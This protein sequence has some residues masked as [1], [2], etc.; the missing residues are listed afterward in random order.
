MG[1]YF[2]PSNLDQAVY[3]KRFTMFRSSEELYIYIY[4]YKVYI[5]IILGMSNSFD[6]LVS[7]LS[8]KTQIALGHTHKEMEEV[9]SSQ[10]MVIAPSKLVMARSKMIPLKIVT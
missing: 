8:M 5:Y 1:T 4:V 2:D 9:V 7:T 6:C 10:K 3:I